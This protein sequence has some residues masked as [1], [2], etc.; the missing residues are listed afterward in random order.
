METIRERI[1]YKNN[2]LSI[3]M[4]SLK[5]VEQYEFIR[6]FLAV[7]HSK[8]TVCCIG[9]CNNYIKLLFQ[10]LPVIQVVAHLE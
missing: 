7:G 1:Q 8:G 9:E 5:L 4:Q 3:C 6:L 2:D 10:K